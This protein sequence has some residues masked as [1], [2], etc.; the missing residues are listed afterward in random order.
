MNVDAKPQRY[1]SPKCKCITHYEAAWH[2]FPRMGNGGLGANHDGHMS[3]FDG[4]LALI[5]ANWKS[6]T[7]KHAL[8]TRTLK[9]TTHRTCQVSA[10]L[11]NVHFDVWGARTLETCNISGAMFQPHPPILYVPPCDHHPCPI[12]HPS[13]FRPFSTFLHFVLLSLDYSIKTIKE[14]NG[15]GF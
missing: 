2:G 9:P 14:S 6:C 10:M 13:R 11:P 8:G 5:S 3:C 12:T 7:V 1:F 15:I 4:G